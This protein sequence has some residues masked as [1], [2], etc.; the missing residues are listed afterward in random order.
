MAVHTRAIQGIPYIARMPIS[1]SPVAVCSWS[2]QAQGPAQLIE[3]VRATGASAVQL[4]LVPLLEN[5]SVWGETFAMLA[6]AHIE[7]V[8]GMLETV[9]E[10]YSSLES[11]RRTGGV[12]PDASWQA[13]RARAQLV[14]R[15]AGDARLSLVT[16]HAGFIPHDEADGTRATVLNRVR[17]ISALFAAHGVRIAL[18]TGQES[19]ATLVDALHAMNEGSIGVNFDPANMILYGMGDPVAAAT[20]LAPYIVQAHIKDAQPAS[21]AGAWGSEVRVGTGAVDWPAFLAALNH[22]SGSIRVAIEREAGGERVA[23][24][25]AARMLLAHHGLDAAPRAEASGAAPRAEASGAAPRTE[26]TRG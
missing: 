9:G 8:S 13:T 21:E 7:V 25:R 23:D 15:I 16:F 26:V 17:E 18:E 20:R 6:D 14:A 22:A 2:L 4:A 5:P 12:A 1:S 19:A 11:I 10:D 24:I 3:L